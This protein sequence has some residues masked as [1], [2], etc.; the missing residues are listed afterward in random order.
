ML[1][2][3]PETLESCPRLI[4]AACKFFKGLFTQRIKQDKN[5]LLQ[6]GASVPI[7]EVDLFPVLW[8]RLCR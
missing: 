8:V 6:T 4:A 2:K 1:A 7:P 5:T 3:D